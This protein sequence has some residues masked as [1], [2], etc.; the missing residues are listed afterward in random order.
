MNKVALRC[1]QTCNVGY[2][3]DMAP[4]L[5]DEQRQALARRPDAPLEVEDP[6]THG[7][8]ALVRMDVYEQMQKVPSYGDTSPDPREFY[9]AFLDAVKNDLDAP[10]MEEYDN[11]KPPQAET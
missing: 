5:S 6:E 3:S 7:K 4:K 10:G 2:N 8:Y 1:F 9:P 11:Y